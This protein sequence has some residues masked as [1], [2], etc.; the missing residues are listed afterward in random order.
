M[1]L[2]L[3]H[4]L[5]LGHIQV[6]A[7]DPLNL[8]PVFITIV[9]TALELYLQHVHSA[10]QEASAWCVRVFIEPHGPR[11]PQVQGFLELPTHCVAHQSPC[12]H[13]EGEEE[14]AYNIG[15][16]DQLPAHK[17]GAVRAVVADLATQEVY[18][19]GDEAHSDQHVGNVLDV[20]LSHQVLPFVELHLQEEPQAEQDGSCH[21]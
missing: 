12:Q 4:H 14:G 6:T 13:A 3:L 19:T 17:L 15:Q 18:G 11:Q 1:L 16:H 10:L 9:S 7:A 21:H 20:P 8:K 5:F 2:H